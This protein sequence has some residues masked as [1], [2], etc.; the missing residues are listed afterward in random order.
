MAN[1]TITLWVDGRKPVRVD[2]EEFAIIKLMIEDAGAV[3]DRRAMIKVIND[4]ISQGY[5]RHRAMDL[6]I[7]AKGELDG[8]RAPS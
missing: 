5:A 1:E 6:C 3:R 7:M 2:R 4:L 8:S